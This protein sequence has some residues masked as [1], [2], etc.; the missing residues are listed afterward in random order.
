MNLHVPAQPPLQSVAACPN[1][2]VATTNNPPNRG[3]TLLKKFLL[4]IIIKTL[5]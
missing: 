1:I 4:D 5:I 3:S 2:G